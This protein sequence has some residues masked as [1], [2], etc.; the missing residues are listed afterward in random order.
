VFGK[1]IS[2]AVIMAMMAGGA[3]AS[4]LSSV[5]GT[6]LVNSGAGFRP[7]SGNMSLAPGDRVKVVSGSASIVY[8]NGCS[9]LVGANQVVAVLSSPPACGGSLK[10]GGLKDG[11]AEDNTTLL[12]GGL[13]IAGGI[14][15]AIALA[16]NH[17]PASP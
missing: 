8:D 2:I 9:V 12:V 11:P 6:V 5:E 15:T 7:A 3:Q 10:E 4:Y 16:E 1:T 13:V 14:G 17:K